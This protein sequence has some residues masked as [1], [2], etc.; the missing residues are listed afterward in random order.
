GPLERPPLSG[1]TSSGILASACIDRQQ[2]YRHNAGDVYTSS[3]ATRTFLPAPRASRG[4]QDHL[5]APRN[6]E[7]ALVQPSS[8]SRVVAPYARAGL[9]SPR[10]RGATLR[11]LGRCGRSAE[12]ARPAQRRSRCIGFG[13]K[14]LALCAYRLLGALAAAR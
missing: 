8:R 4:R 5:A 7:R 6:S 3:L 10:N 1:R 13:P 9:V 2:Y 14:A 12:T 11:L